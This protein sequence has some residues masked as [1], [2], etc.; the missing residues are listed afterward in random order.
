[1]ELPEMIVKLQMGLC[2]VPRSLSILGCVNITKC[3]LNVASFPT[4]QSVSCLLFIFPPTCTV[5]NRKPMTLYE[6]QRQPTRLQLRHIICFWGPWQEKIKLRWRLKNLTGSEC[7][8]KVARG[9]VLRRIKCCGFGG[10]PLAYE[11]SQR[12]GFGVTLMCMRSIVLSEW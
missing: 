2:S 3:Y 4:E 9:P 6:W 10:Y 7:N 12:C 8:W 11:V 1:M 5:I